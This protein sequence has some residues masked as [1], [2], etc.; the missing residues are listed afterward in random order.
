M[1]TLKSAFLR[2]KGLR[3]HIG[4]AR[5]HAEIPAEVPAEVPAEAPVDGCPPIE[6][7]VGFPAGH[8]YSPIPDRNEALAYLESRK[9]LPARL[10]EIELNREEQ[11]KLLHEYVSFYEE[12][13]LPEKKTP[14]RRYY[15]ENEW[16]GY[17][18]AFFLHAFLRKHQPKRIIEVGSGF[19][20]A[21]MLDTVDEFF[22]QR[23]EITLVE[24]YPE[25]LQSLLKGGDKDAVRIIVKRVQ[26]VPLDLFSSLE[27]GDFLFIDS[28]HV[29]K[30]GSDVQR[31]MFDILPVLA[32]GAFVHFHDVFYPFEYP[33][34]W[35]GEGRYWNE[36]YLLR[37]FLA[38]NAEWTINLFNA[39]VEF[40]FQDFLRE[41]MPHCANMPGGSLYLRRKER[42]P[43][44]ERGRS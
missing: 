40:A 5:V 24:P 25:R 18:D 35:L 39:Y 29:L 3:R 11:L 23:P 38:Y 8:Y 12:T 14:Q 30:C 37:A 44:S 32:P 6:E 22:A 42:S 41:K 28:S 20:S 36:D 34:K 2:V 17:S 16:F 10:P 19:S 21:I 1:T 9:P 13:P 4:H 27:S 7:P 43:T 33:S 31:L 15:Y 26:D